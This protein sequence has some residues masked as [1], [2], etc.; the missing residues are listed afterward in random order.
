MSANV[1]ATDFTAPPTL[2]P[3]RAYVTAAGLVFVS[4]QTGVDPATGTLPD[5]FEAECRQAFQ[6][7]V[8]AVRSSGGGAPD[9]VKTTVLYT[10]AKDFPVINAVF[11]EVFPVLP[12]A[13]T[14]AIVGLPDGKRVAVDAIAVDRG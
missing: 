11:A 13:R 2:G 14:S 8:D 12:P 3:Y 9:V 10:D 6:N 4:A 5:T 1:A 7:L